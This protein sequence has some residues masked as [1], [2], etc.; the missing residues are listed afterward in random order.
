MSLCSKA[1]N[2]STRP[3]NGTSQLIDDIQSRFKCCGRD[4]YHD[5]QESASVNP[6]KKFLFLNNEFLLQRGQIGFNLP[7]SCCVLVRDS[8]GKE[9]PLESE[10]ATRGCLE[11]LHRFLKL[12][13][14]YVYG[15]YLATFLV[16]LL[17]IF[18]FLF[19]TL[20]VKSDYNLVEAEKKPDTP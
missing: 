8:C 12:L 19:V 6:S 9:M 20:A 16:I 14:A 13:L 3:S 18:Y 4:S 15:S 2:E 5:W 17:S 7:D 10:I 1:Y 11:P